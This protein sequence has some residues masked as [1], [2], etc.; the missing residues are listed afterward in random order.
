MRKKFPLIARNLA[1]YL[2]LTLAIIFVFI[3]IYWT[4]NTSLKVPY[5]V[6]SFP[7][8]WIPIPFSLESYVQIFTE[9]VLPRNYLNSLILVA[10]TM[11]LVLAIG[12]PAGYAA[13]R[14]DFRGKNAVLFLLMM[15]VMVPGIVTLIPQ[16]FLAVQ[17]GLHDTYLLLILIFGAWQVPTVLWIMRGF[18]QNIPRELDESA[19]VDGCSRIGA[20]LRIVL[21]LS[22]PGI[23]AA[24]IIVF[25]WVWN[26]F[27]IALNLTASNATRPLTVGIYFFVGETGIQW[28][29]MSAGAIV[30]L[31]PVIIF[32]ILLQ[33]RFVEGLTAGAVKG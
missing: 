19:L 33:R 7:P 23:A 14:Y 4:L 30:A 25:V 24:A 32:F 21:P 20:F 8:K 28:G 31:L 15:T 22:V 12:V 13:A 16:Y 17:L 1:I 29:G 3:P 9:S 11:V 10:G 2:P 5:Q 18:F 27:I 6:V 26:E